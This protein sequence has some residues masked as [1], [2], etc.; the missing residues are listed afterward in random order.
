MFSRLTA[1]RYSRLNWH[2][3]YWDVSLSLSKEC[4]NWSTLHEKWYGL[5]WMQHLCLLNHSH[6]PLGRGK[7]VSL[8]QSAVW[9]WNHSTVSPHYPAL[10]F[11]STALG[12]QLPPAQV[13]HTGPV[14]PQ[15][16]EPS[17]AT[18]GT[19]RTMNTKRSWSAQSPQS[20]EEMGGHERV[21][22]PEPDNLS[23]LLG[24]YVVEGKNQL[25]QTSSDVHTVPVSL[26]DAR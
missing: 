14:H 2:Y 21:L 11:A 25:P 24:T 5:L 13:G 4:L 16:P 1:L 12:A 17:R 8:S 26:G 3:L 22:A 10:P 20:A 7:G 19:E 9:I 18:Q 6:R 23:S 15:I